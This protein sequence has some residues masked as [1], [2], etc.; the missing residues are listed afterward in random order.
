M[1]SSHEHGTISQWNHRSQVESKPLVTRNWQ[2]LLV[3]LLAA[4]AFAAAPGVRAADGEP[5]PFGLT[6]RVAP[7]H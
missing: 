3:C 5:R 4:M 7:Q 6:K 2:W 1:L